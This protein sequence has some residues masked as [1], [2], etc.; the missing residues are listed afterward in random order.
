V[1]VVYEQIERSHPI[2]VAYFELFVSYMR[3]FLLLAT[4]TERKNIFA[5]YSAAYA[6][7]NQGKKC[8]SWNEYV[9]LG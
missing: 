6:T 1:T 7:L 8:P 3:V 5:L 9:C 4:F 2:I